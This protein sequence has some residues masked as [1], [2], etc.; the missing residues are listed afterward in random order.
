MI[1]R[2]IL[3]FLL[4]V[5]GVSPG[6]ADSM[7]FR[8]Y[9]V[10]F[11]LVF[12]YQ[13]TDQAGQARDVTF[14]LK[15]QVVD[16]SR[17]LFIPFDQ[18]QANRIVLARLQEKARGYRGVQPRIRL[19]EA[20]FEIAVSGV[21]AAQINQ[22][23]KELEQA[24]EQFK[25]DYYR[26]HFLIED[27]SKQYVLP[28]HK[29][30]VAYYAPVMAPMARAF[31]MHGLWQKPRDMTGLLLGFLQSIPYDDLQNRATSNGAG[32]ATPPE[33]LMDHRGDCDSKAVTLAALLRSLYP[34][35]KMIMVYTPNHAF[36]GVQVPVR[37]GDRRLQID[38]QDYVLLEPAGPAIIPVGKLADPSERALEQGTF[39]YVFL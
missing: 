26:D 22:V 14:R 21:N 3:C 1:L 5:G 2:F 29:R 18:D 32:F 36:L 37:K 28:D 27:H 13:F 12:S 16:D 31:D 23:G 9:G 33:M 35:M 34:S 7:V 38:G 30:L 8:S 15:K 19:N 6:F 11:D 17:T 24:A 39:R 4:W 25:Q 10:A 20:G